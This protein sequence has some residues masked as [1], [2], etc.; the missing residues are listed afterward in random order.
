MNKYTLG[1]II[2][3]AALGLAKPKTPFGNRNVFQNIGLPIW[4]QFEKANKGLSNGSLQGVE[5]AGD[6]F[7]LTPLLKDNS[8]DSIITS[9]PY[10]QM[11][12][13]SESNQE[14]GQ[15]MSR[16]EYIETLVNLFVDLMPKLKD[17]G[18]LVVNIDALSRFSAVKVMGVP[19]EFVCKMEAS[20]WTLRYDLK[21]I[22]PSFGGWRSAFSPG[23]NFEHIF[24]FIKTSSVKKGIKHYNYNQLHQKGKTQD[25]KLFT[26][27]IYE[28]G[29]N[30]NS[31]SKDD[32]HRF[33]KRFNSREDKHLLSHLQSNAYMHGAPL[34]P[35][36]AW[37]LVQLFSKPGNFVLDP[38]SGSGTVTK[39][40]KLCGRKS[41]GFELE[42]VHS[43]LAVIGEAF[44]SNF[45]NIQ[46]EYRRSGKDKA[47]FKNAEGIS[48][49]TE[50]KEFESWKDYDPNKTMWIDASYLNVS[51]SRS[52]KSGMI[53]IHRSIDTTIDDTITNAR[54][55]VV[56]DNTHETIAE[57]GLQDLESRLSQFC[58]EINQKIDDKRYEIS[59]DL[60]DNEYER[61]QLQVVPTYLNDFIDLLD[62][63]WEKP[64]ED[65]HQPT[66]NDVQA[67]FER[68]N[69][70]MKNLKVAMIQIRVQYDY[71]GP[72]S[73]ASKPKDEQS[74]T[75]LLEERISGIF[76][77]I[78][79]PI[80]EVVVLDMD[81]ADYFYV[82]DKSGKEHSINSNDRS[83]LR[84]R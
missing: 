1:T 36:V 76:E 61:Y 19:Y 25:W 29:L 43:K 68:E 60:S 26:A 30:H 11:R 64:I 22:K 80:G 49:H 48:N 55:P 16:S 10:F 41:I 42:K 82:V 20:G 3:A 51:G 31:W 74:L 12:K 78:G 9:P 18:V 62:D 73:S 63:R 23:K 79:H 56:W 28:N 14:I 34:N 37:I 71:R 5:V 35:R 47:L 21:W 65:I 33:L 52:R 67:I 40:S 2:G 53:V 70:S 81:Y 38:F 50:I 17:D 57:L 13:Y 24:G 83:K 46:K 15:E 59:D 77:S 4:R 66:P 27:T 32:S 69:L 6:S 72:I 45:D 54:I 84:K 39:V 75:Q 8:I 7:K 58:L 44:T